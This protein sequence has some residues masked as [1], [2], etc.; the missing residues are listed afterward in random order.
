MKRS[1][2]IK[3][4]RREITDGDVLREAY[5]D[6]C[7]G[8]DEI[9]LW[10]HVT[11]DKSGKLIAVQ[12]GCEPP[13][14]TIHEIFSVGGTR[15]LVW[16]N[17]IAISGDAHHRDHFG[18]K[19]EPVSARVLAILAKCRKREYLGD[20]SEFFIPEANEA[21]GGNGKSVAGWVETRVF[22]CPFMRAFQYE[23]VRRLA[24]LTELDQGVDAA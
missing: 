1:G 5:R 17:F 21:A 24:I 20:A 13:A 11:W 7:Q 12:P 8:L 3:P 19:G 16:S 23:T 14:V 18:T 4:K 2:R 15:P 10:V 6:Q 9:A 22:D